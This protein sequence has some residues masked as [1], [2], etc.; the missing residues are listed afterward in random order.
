MIIVEKDHFTYDGSSEV[1]VDD[2]SDFD[3]DSHVSLL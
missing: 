1:V 3:S 2:D